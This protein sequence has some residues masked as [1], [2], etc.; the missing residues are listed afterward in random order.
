MVM[1]AYL[2]HDLRSF[3]NENPFAKPKMDLTTKHVLSLW[4]G[5][6]TSKLG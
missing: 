3:P 6:I 2:A 1:E 5:V 4:M